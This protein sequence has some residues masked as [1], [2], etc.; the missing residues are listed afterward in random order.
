MNRI[1]IAGNW[2]MNKTF[3]EAEEFVKGLIKEDLAK[4]DAEIQLF[5]PALYLKSLTEL[6][7]GSKVVIGAQNIHQE[8]AGAYTGEISVDML[9]SIKISDTLIGHSER[10]Q[11]FNETNDIV[12]K[13]TLLALKNGIKP[14]VC[15]G[16]TLEEREANITNQVLK[17]QTVEAL[18]DVVQADMEKIIVA[19]EPVW[20][21][22]TGKT[23]TAN[24]ANE[25]CKYVR[26]VVEELYGTEIAQNLVI[27]YG[28]SVKPDNVQEILAQS[29]ING[30]L[31]GGASLELASYL[32]LIK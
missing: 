26:S 6:T 1:V 32:K 16:E 24:D 29:D 30:A 11:Y 5:V 22:G 17:T 2:K 28:G 14:V 4:I 13:K 7:K 8:V 19:Y 12:N 3:Q 23:A 27:Q 21:I 20:A 18:K 25:A 31:V 10:R 15:I 9:N